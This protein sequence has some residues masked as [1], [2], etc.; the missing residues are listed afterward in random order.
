MRRRD[1]RAIMAV[2]EAVFPEPWSH[3]IFTSELALRRERAYQVARRGRSLVGYYGLLFVDDEAHVTTLAVSPEHQGRGMGTAVLLHAV[4]LAL[5]RG[6]RHLCS[7]WRPA[8]S[9]P[10]GCTGASASSRWGCA[11]TTTSAPARTPTSCG[12][13]DADSPA[14]AERLAGIATRLRSAG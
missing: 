11:R 13:R 14:Y 10:R 6:V 7:R 8:T 5:G 9:G 4:Q 2:E 12:L 3:T 1:L